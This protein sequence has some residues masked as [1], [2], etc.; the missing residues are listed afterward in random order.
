[1]S[2]KS[3][4]LV[5]GASRGIGQAI[6][7]SFQQAG[8]QVFGTAT[9]ASGADAISSW[10]GAGRGLQLDISDGASCD[11]ALA[12]VAE[13]GNLYALVN[14]A[15]ITRDN[16][17]LRM[18]DNEWEQVISANLT[19][20]YNMCW[21]VARGMI[22]QRQ[23]RIINVGSIIGSIGNIGQINYAA[24]KAGVSGMSKTL[25]LELG[26]RGITVN[27]IAPGFV[28]T[29]MTE[30]LSAEVKEQM[31]ARIPL[32]RFAQAD[33][34]AGLAVFLASAGAGYITGQTIHINGGLHFSS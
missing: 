1:M 12:Q 31:L 24:A 18:K 7:L 13:A 28:L 14:N 16:I 10:L 8:Y 25:A 30:Q 11:A 21:R 29:D 32:G 27:V 4:V 9:S 17:V 6:A 19:G 23:G 5:T 34:I 26:A 20:T 33:E 22:K 2:A 15:G 3:I